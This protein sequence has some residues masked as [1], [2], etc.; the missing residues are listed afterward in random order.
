M[1][2]LVNFLA[3]G[4]GS[5]MG[6]QIQIQLSKINED[7]DPQHYFMVELR[8]YGIVFVILVDLDNRHHLPPIKQLSSVQLLSKAIPNDL[9]SLYESETLSQFFL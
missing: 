9:P 8:N 1:L 2:I 5:V 4:S 7:P 6:M 3:P